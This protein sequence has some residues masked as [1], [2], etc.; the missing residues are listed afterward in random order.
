MNCKHRSYRGAASAAVAIASMP[1]RRAE[2]ARLKALLA[3]RFA[4]HERR[5]RA[6][7]PVVVKR[8][9]HGAPI[10][11]R[12]EVTRRRNAREGVVKVNNVVRIGPP[13][14]P[15]LRE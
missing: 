11:S 7:Q 5:V 3:H 14:R 15:E 6:N 8:L 2:G 4:A 13:D 10:L 9:N 1:D 12:R